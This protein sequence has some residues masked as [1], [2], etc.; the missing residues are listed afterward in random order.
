[1]T[2]IVIARSFEASAKYNGDQ[3][4][5]GLV[6]EQVTQIATAHRRTEGE[7]RLLVCLVGSVPD[8]S[9]QACDPDCHSRTSA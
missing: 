5:L 9:N 7:S 8:L 2:L 4:Q 3:D 1:M 6:Q